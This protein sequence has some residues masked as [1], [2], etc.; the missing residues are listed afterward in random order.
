MDI[1]Y[2]YIACYII[3]ANVLYCVL[4]W[5]EL[6][7]QYSIRNISIHYS[8]SYNV[9]VHLC[10]K[11]D[12]R[13]SFWKHKLMIITRGARESVPGIPGACANR[14]F[15][16]LARGP[17]LLLIVSDIIT[18]IA[19]YNRCA[20]VGWLCKLSGY[21]WR[22]NEISRWI[23]FCSHRVCMRHAARQRID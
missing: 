22:T 8:S 23:G 11:H 1:L 21:K 3:D 15:T 20:W 9:H 7:M 6:N 2:P 17:L 12:V 19:N 5:T 18:P 10:Y 16:Y 14:N 4:S 13:A